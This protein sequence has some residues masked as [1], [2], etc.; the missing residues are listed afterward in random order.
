MLLGGLLNT[1]IRGRSWPSLS[2]IEK[3]ALE[4]ERVGPGTAAMLSM[5]LTHR[6]ILTDSD[7]EIR[8]RCR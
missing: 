8:K 6:C 4:G 3:V 1:C 5:L 2:S 7:N